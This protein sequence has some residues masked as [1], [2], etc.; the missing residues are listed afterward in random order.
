MSVVSTVRALPV[1]WRIFLTCWL[2]YSLHFSLDIVREHYPAFSLAERGTL[3]VDPY[4]GLHPDL[5]EIPGRGGF[6]NNNPGASLFGAVPY[7]LLRPAVDLAVERVNHVRAAR[8]GVHSIEYDDPRPLRRLFFKRVRE[9]GLDVRF[10]LAAG[11]IHVFA[12]APLSAAAVVVMFL[13]LGRLGISRAWQI[14]L[15]LLY[16]F[17]TPVFFRT[18]F[19]NHNLL[20]AHATLVSFALLFDPHGPVRARLR[21]LAAGI[22]AGVCLLCDYSG[23]VPLASLGLY[24]LGRRWK[25]GGFAEAVGAAAVMAA[26][27]SLPVAV[28]LGY[29][30]WAF[31]NPFLPAQHYMPATELSVHGWAGFDWPSADM[32]IRNLLDPAYGLFTFGPLLLLALGAPFLLQRGR[33]ALPGPEMAFAFGL[34]V[35]LLLFTS[36]NQFAR[37]Q[38]N[39]GFRMLSAALPG[40]FLCAAAVLARMPPRLAAGIALLAVLHGWCIAMARAGALESVRRVLADGPTFPWLTSLWRAGNEYLPLATA[41]WGFALSL[42]AVLGTGLF[43]L[44][45]LP[46]GIAPH[47]WTRHA[48]RG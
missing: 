6:I 35:A 22:A 13:V 31:G 34:F 27:A 42:L 38:W 40:L 43:V 46:P 18:G 1:A 26:G 12:T 7:L 20:V 33:S 23:I 5:F 28:L 10:G 36:G 15:A 16:G 3:R 2:V 30:Q 24:A 48:E 47:A 39:T 19:L 45:G 37:L 41:R 4:L 21:L 29:Q 8:G 14:G 32:L 44:W 11:V 25:H 17:G 9:E